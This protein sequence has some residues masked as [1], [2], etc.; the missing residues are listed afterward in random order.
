MVNLINKITLATA[1][2]AITIASGQINKLNQQN[3]VQI[4]LQQQQFQQIQQKQ[5]DFSSSRSNQQQPQQ[6]QQQLQQPSIH[7]QINQD[8]MRSK[9]TLTVVQPLMREGIRVTLS[10]PS[11]RYAKLEN[12]INILD[13]VAFA[14]SKP[15]TIMNIIR[16]VTLALSSLIMS[17]F[18]FPSTLF[19][20]SKKSRRERFNR[21]N[22]LNQITRADIES[23]IDLM[24]RN[25][26]ET[27]NRAGL[28]EKNSC[29][30]RSLCV[31]GDMVSCEFPNVVLT[32]GKFAQNHLPPIDT[33]RN[34]YTKAIVMGLNQ[35]DCDQ[36]YK[37]TDYDCPTFRD[38]VRSYFYR[39]A[40]RRREYNTW[41]PH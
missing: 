13:R 30:E 36:A 28:M 26:D 5:I 11:F 40:R 12:M 38:Y 25:Y 41:R 14:I 31:L 27:L 3:Y 8:P 19:E 4:P 15:A 37:L 17:S 29:R 35:T 21:Y 32:A 20:L 33:N 34:K 1:I 7:Q 2:I 16:F 22:P 24:S 39:G 23:M 9:Q 10:E 6:R 18:I